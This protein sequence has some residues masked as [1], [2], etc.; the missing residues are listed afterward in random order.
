MKEARGELTIE[1]CAALVKTIRANLGNK[2]AALAATPRGKA[3]RVTTPKAK[4]DA[5]GN[6]D[7]F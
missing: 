5:N 6:V 3:S 7:F 4:E 1:E 2:S